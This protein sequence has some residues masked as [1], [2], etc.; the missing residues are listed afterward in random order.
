MTLAK[1]IVFLGPPGCGKGTQ[2]S[3]I[4]GKVGVP[5]ISTGDML[6]E[7]VAAGTPLGQKV[8]SIMNSGALVDD[9]TMADLVRERLGRPDVEM[10]FLL[11]GYPRTSPQG[12]TLAEILDGQG[13]ALDRVVL[14]EVPESILMVRAL[15][16][17]RPDDTE[18]VIRK[19]LEVYR[20]DTAPL[21]DRYRQEGLLATI[22]GNQ[23]IDEVTVALLGALQV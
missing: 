2:A 15:N 12:N 17:K 3:R 22:D 1:R 6:R 19:R 18:E 20:D 10:G 23:S 14:F 11:D 13:M 16:R 8:A 4:S 7:S 9:A 21:I 5:A